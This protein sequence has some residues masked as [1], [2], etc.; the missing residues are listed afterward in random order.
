MSIYFHV[1]ILFASTVGSPEEAYS[2][3]KVAEHF[4]AVFETWSQS[5]LLQKCFMDFLAFWL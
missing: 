1:F 4:S 5:S 3:T 2:K